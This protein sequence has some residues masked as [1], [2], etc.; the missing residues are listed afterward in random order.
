MPKPSTHESP[1]ISMLEIITV[2]TGLFL[3]VGLAVLV[4][5]LMLKLLNG[6]IEIAQAPIPS[7]PSPRLQL[8]PQADLTEMRRRDDQRLHQGAAIPIE[9][10]MELIAQRGQDAFSPLVPANTRSGGQR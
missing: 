2:T 6:N 10:A 7:F 9:K 5:A 8:S 1:A 4:V 3:L